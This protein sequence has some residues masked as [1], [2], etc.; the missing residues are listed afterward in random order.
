MIRRKRRA[1][2]KSQNEKTIT[3]YLAGG[4]GLSTRSEIDVDMNI[5]SKNKYI[6]KYLL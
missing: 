6:Y 4:F 3:T 5:F 1:D 2:K